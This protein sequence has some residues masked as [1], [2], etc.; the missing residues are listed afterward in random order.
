MNWLIYQHVFI[1]IGIYVAIFY[2]IKEGLKWLSKAR[3]THDLDTARNLSKEVLAHT[4]YVRNMR[5]DR[6]TPEEH[7]KLTEAEDAL[8]SAIAGTDLNALERTSKEFDRYAKTLWKEPK[9]DKRIRENLRSW[10]WHLP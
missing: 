1:R 6:M 9:K 10:S 8:K 2:A 7:E 5:E 4:R 3:G